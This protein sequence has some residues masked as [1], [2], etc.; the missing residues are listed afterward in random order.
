MSARTLCLLIPMLCGLCGCSAF[1][2]LNAL[3]PSDGYVRTKSIAYGP[4]PRQKLDLYQ[5][6]RGGPHAGIVVFFYGGDWQSGNKGAYRFV[7]EG[8]ISKGFI[9]VLPDYRLYPAVRF[10]AFVEDGALAV[11]WVHDHAREIGG[12]PDDIFLMGHS[13]GGH[14]AALLTLDG[15]Y[16]RA[17][18]L[19][20]RDIAA[21]AGLAGPYEF[22]PPRKDRRVFDMPKGAEA[23]APDVEP[24]NF[25]DGREAPMLLLTGTQD[26]TVP[27]E[28]ALKLA[29]RIWQSGG[30]AT[31]I[32][33]EKVGHV[34]LV[35]SLAAPF[36]WI[37]PALEDVNAFFRQHE[38]PMK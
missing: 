11:R 31:Y 3:A 13:A 9:A 16:L 26:R 34:Q 7:A 37:S 30:V 4:L 12:N 20:R 19:D 36:R 2:V 18:G 25:V 14:I 35:L 21:T 32:A 24:I 15:R 5:P 28:N 22:L 17:V 6:R 27:P 38:R 29:R 33:Y 1:D 10:P 8:L 23:P